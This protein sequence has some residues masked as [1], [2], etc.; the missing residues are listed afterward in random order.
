MSRGAH[1]PLATPQ[2]I[3]LEPTAFPRVTAAE[4]EET[5]LAD[6]RAR[7]THNLARRSDGRW[8]PL[9]RVHRKVP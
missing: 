1:P 2:A 9:T 5:G 3:A 6:W 7:L 8:D 4:P